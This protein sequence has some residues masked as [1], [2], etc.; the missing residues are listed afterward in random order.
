MNENEREK[1]QGD[2]ARMNVVLHWCMVDEILEALD[3]SSHPKAA[4]LAELLNERSKKTPI[5][6]ASQEL[7]R[8]G[9]DENDYDFD[10]SPTVSP[11]DRSIGGSGGAY[12]QIWRWI[13]RKDAIKKILGGQS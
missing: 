13:S 12:V 1:G 9:L 8:G 4:R 11:C 7:S 6:T 3:E 2:Q 10:D 5:D